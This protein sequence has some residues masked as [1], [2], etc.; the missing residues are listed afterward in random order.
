[1]VM[2]FVPNIAPRGRHIMLHVRQMNYCIAL[3][4]RYDITKHGYYIDQKTFLGRFLRVLNWTN[5]HHN[6]RGISHQ[7]Q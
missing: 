7:Y 3:H 6:H 5:Q 1:M 4:E 2:V